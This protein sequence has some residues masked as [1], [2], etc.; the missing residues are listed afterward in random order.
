MQDNGG[1]AEDF[2]GG[3]V[4]M[5]ARNLSKSFGTHNVLRDVSLDIRAGEIL[6][7]LGPNGAGKSTMLNI[8]GGTL[9]PSEGTSPEISLAH[10][11]S[12]HKGMSD[13]DIV[14]VKYT[15]DWTLKNVIGAK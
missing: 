12:D 2:H 9:A 14:W 1:S 11:K 4:F 15:Y 10:L 3:N 5:S 8:V 13:S 7:L 6:V